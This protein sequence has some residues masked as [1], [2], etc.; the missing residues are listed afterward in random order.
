MNY[1]ESDETFEKA[2]NIY[3]RDNGDISSEKKLAKAVALVESR[4]Y[5]KWTRV[6]YTIEFAHEMG[7]KTLGIAT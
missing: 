1:E 4:G 2:G 7:Y 5:Q 3:E 6:E